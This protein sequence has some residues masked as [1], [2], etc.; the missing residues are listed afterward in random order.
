MKQ[1]I[2][3]GAYGEITQYDFPTNRERVSELVKAANSGAAVD[4]HGAW[5]FGIQSSNRRGTRGLA[6][7]WDCYG[8]G[9]DIHTGTFLALIQVRQTA[10]NKYGNSSRKSYFLL[11]HNEDDS[12]FAHCVESRTIHAALAAN[13]D[14]VL[15]SQSW[16]FECDYA[17]VIRQ[18]DLALVP[19][20]HTPH[21]SRTDARAESLMRSHLL[22]ADEIRLN[23]VYYALNPVVVHPVHPRISAS[24]WYKIICANRARFWDFSKTRVD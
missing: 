14:P 6:L 15:A 24:G 10:W 22:R 11:G 8:Y 9:T 3:R 5:K 21:A 19:L 7:N 2:T 16:M 13:R 18:G 23:G 1:E 12:V 4:E 20:T 17:R